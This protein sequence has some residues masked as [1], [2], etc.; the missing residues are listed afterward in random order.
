MSSADNDSRRFRDH[1]DEEGKVDGFI[2]TIP[3][4]LTG[5]RR[6]EFLGYL[7]ATAHP[8]TAEAVS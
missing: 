2:V 1:I 7:L 3:A 8:L 5:E 4:H 6:K